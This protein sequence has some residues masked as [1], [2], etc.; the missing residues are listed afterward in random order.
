VRLAIERLTKEH[1]K[2]DFDCGE[3]S[4]NN[5]LQRLA[6]QNDS[7]GVGRTFVAVEE[8]KKRIRGYYTLAAGKI[9]FATF[10]ESKKLPPNLPVPVILLGR[11][12]VDLS[13][14]G[15]GLG[16]TLLLHALWRC[17][18]L[19]AHAGVHAVEVDAL[20]EKAKAFYQKFGFVA[21]FDDPLHLYLPMKTIEALALDFT[22]DTL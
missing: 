21:L 19:A 4:L 8:G 16:S 15:T 10:P 2:A 9:D 3:A 22:E 5:F 13:T 12:A 20:H 1:E 18:Q 11:L 6:L 14:Q 7:R 17:Q